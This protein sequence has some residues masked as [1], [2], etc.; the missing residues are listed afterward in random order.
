[1]EITVN[2]SPRDLPDGATV[3]DL[4]ADIGGRADGRGLA[5]AVDSQVVPHSAWEQTPLSAGDQ[6][7]IL[8]A[9]QG[10]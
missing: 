8:V 9:V 4:V 2:G 6:V 7:E 1:M 3:A 10:G 5:V